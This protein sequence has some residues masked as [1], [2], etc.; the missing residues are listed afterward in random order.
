[1][2]SPDSDERPKRFYAQAEAGPLE[3]GF[4][5]LLDRRPARTPAG[6]R[7]ILPTHALAALIAEEW[8]GQG[9]RI[10]LARMEATRLAFTAADHVGAR[11]V[12]SVE[13][14][15]RYAGSDLLCYFADAPQAL[16]ERQAAQWGPLLDWAQ[17]ELGFALHRTS[18]IVHRAQPPETVARAQ[19]LALAL[20]DFGLAALLRAAGLFGSAVL[21][22]AVQRGRLGGG[23]AYERSRLD[24]AFQEEKWGV[25]AEAAARRAHLAAEA[26]RLERWFRALN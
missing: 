26:E 8:A 6:A 9:E 7:L 14:I 15:G 17:A 11:R 24:E 20:D 16:I 4:G 25:D 3:G 19:A 13:E 2:P 23:E 12:Q 18:G 1:M 10:D 22:F 21:A 5:V